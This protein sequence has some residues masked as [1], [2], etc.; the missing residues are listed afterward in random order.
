[1]L[2]KLQSIFQTDHSKGSLAKVLTKIAED[3]YQSKQAAII[4]HSRKRLEILF[5]CRMEF[6]STSIN[7][8][9]VIENIKPLTR[10]LKVYGVYKNGKI[11][12]SNKK[13][14]KRC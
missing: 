14:D 13:P 5:S 2:I 6:E 3:G 1:M 7:L 12:L 8:N 9:T 10:E 11:P 4:S